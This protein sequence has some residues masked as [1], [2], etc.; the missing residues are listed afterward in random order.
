MRF[1]ANWF[2]LGCASHDPLPVP[3]AGFIESQVD[4]K[5]LTNYF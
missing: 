4:S 2:N 1:V 3:L 5:L